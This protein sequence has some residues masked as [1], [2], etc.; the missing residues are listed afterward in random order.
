MIHIAYTINS[1]YV[2]YCG[3][4]MLSA[5]RTAR[6]QRFAFHVIA[7]DLTGPDKD[8]LTRLAEKEGATV[9]FYTVPDELTSHYKVTWDANR[10]PMLVYYRCFLA[11]LLPR[12]VEKVIYM[13]CDTLV[14]HSLRELWETPLEGKAIAA[15]RDEVRFKPERVERLMYDASYGYF[16]G[17]VLLINL[18]YWREHHVE[19][20]LREFYRKYPERIVYNDQDLLNAVLYDKKVMVSAR[21]NVQG[22]FY[23][24]KLVL[25]EHYE[26]EHLDAALHPY[27]IHYTS[28]KKPWHLYC[29]HPYKE[30]CREY[31]R[32]VTPETIEAMRK[33]M[34]RLRRV[35][36]LL[37]YYLRLKPWKYMTK[38]EMRDLG[39]KRGMA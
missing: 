11:T 12:E 7:N 21:W 18:K 14:L 2:K 30:E 25:S 20:A 16:N 5:A 31:L 35:L 9:S 8:F 33:P 1:G 34:A 4:A 37:P 13:D 27:V 10:L 17:G 23:K 36:H 38:E 3:V 28:R 39:R 24:R 22:M 26:K 32:E 29:V 19:E 15:C 6:E